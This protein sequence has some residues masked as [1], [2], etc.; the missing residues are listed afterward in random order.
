MNR[1]TAR[2]FLL[3]ILLA[4]A[5]PILCPAQTV[6]PDHSDQANQP[7]PLASV[8][9][10]LSAIF[11]DA[12]HAKSFAQVS[13]SPDGRLFAWID[14]ESRLRV[15]ERMSDGNPGKELEFR[16]A[17]GCE[18]ARAN[19]FTWAPDSKSI[20]YFASCGSEQDNLFLAAISGTVRARQLTSLKGYVSAPSFSPDGRRV[21]F[22]YVE[23]AT[24]PANALAAIKPWSGVIGEEGLEIMRIAAAPVNTEKPAAPEFLTPAGLHVY[25]FDWRPDGNGLAFIA[26]EPP[27]ENNWWVA[28]L[29]TEELR[30][31]KAGQPRAI[32][33][34]AEVPG[35]LHGLQIAVPRWSPD[36]AS[37][38]FIGGLM[39]DQGVTGGD[40]WIVS[41]QGGEPRNLTPG[42]PATPA[43]LAWSGNDHIFI[44][45]LAGGEEELV[46]LHLAGERGAEGV[47]FG[48]PVFRVPASVGDG[49][50]EMSL[51]STADQSLF[52]F[53]ASGFERAPEIYGVRPGAVMGGSGGFSGLMPLTAV[54][55]GAKPLGGT[56]RSLHWKNEGF[57]IQGWL[58]EPAGYDPQK[59]AGKKFPLIVVVH[60]GPSSAATARWGMGG[61]GAAV[62]SRLGYFVL[63]P[64]P[65][66]SY[67]QG[68]AFTQ[69]NRKDFGYGDLRDILAGM[70]AVEARYPVDGKRIG[71]TGWSYGGFMTMCAVTQ[72]H[73]FRAAVA[74]AGIANWQSYYGENSID[75]WMLPFFGASVYDDPSAYAK[76]SAI[77][78]IKNVSTP[79][80]VLVGDRDGECPA[81][82]SFEFWHALR[83][84][85]VQTRLVVFHNEGHMFSQPGDWMDVMARSVD[86]FGREMAP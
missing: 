24:R 53:Q 47:N 12:P 71:L 59:D 85:H 60:G 1:N 14:S 8:R 17:E 65:R 67:G 45:E 5:A 42:R 74:G 68:E 51:S 81:P 77:N 49:R 36:A 75:Q 40:L 21:G 48:A 11:K 30:E 26:A 6:K 78:F 76:S 35:P 52:V 19:A 3:A 27:G 23:G 37:I 82:Q 2:F 4:A 56:V 46:K 22:L 25:E 58:T 41:A 29:Y 86:W 57:S 84:L 69:A 61:M 55:S 16:Q 66:G 63:E 15:I 38:A 83:S 31:G 34:P 64:N 9:E 62:F 18:A 54:N 43:W 10:K 33:A 32:L 70:D 72:T 79:T 39:S 44:T 20:A 80:L 13:V 28:R 7:D 50:M 73:R